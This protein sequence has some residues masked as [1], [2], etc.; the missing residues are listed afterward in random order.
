[1][2]SK[3]SF[4]KKQECVCKKQ[5]VSAN[6]SCYKKCLQ[7]FHAANSKTCL[8]KAK[9]VC[10][11]F[12]LQKVSTKLTFCRKQK[13]LQNSKVSAKLSCL[14]KCLQNFVLNNLWLNLICRNLKELFGGLIA[15]VATFILIYPY[16][17]Y[18]KNS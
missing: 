11:T 12:I 9:S 6:L 16:S 4:C 7:N 5:K 8:Q 18:Q 17:T 3:L 2:S 1:M 10:K 15:Y 13:C 14:K